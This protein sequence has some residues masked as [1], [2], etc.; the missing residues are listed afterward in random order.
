MWWLIQPS[1][2]GKS[3]TVGDKSFVRM[4]GKFVNIEELAY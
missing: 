1:K 3:K 2:M 4:A